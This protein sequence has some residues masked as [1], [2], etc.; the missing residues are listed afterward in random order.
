[1][2]DASKSLLFMRAICRG[3]RPVQLTQRN[4]RVLRI[5]FP[6][7]RCI[8]HSGEGTY[9]WRVGQHL[10][11][12]LRPRL[13]RRC[14]RNALFHSCYSLNWMSLQHVHMDCTHCGSKGLVAVDMKSCTFWATTP[15]SPLKINGSLGGI[16]RLHLHGG[17]SKTRNQ[18]EAGTTYARVLLGICID[19]EDGGDMF[20]RTVGWFSEDY[21]ASY[22][23]PQDSSRYQ[24]LTFNVYWQSKVTA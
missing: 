10:K 9:K 18:R 13:L 23:R 20:L 6:A 21:M 15:C 12:V 14:L 8:A 5:V 4:K 11:Y 3:T 24:Q 17:I 22:P 16:W 1:M 2:T 7:L 19:H